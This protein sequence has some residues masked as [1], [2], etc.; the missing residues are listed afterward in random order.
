MAIIKKSC[1]VCKK[2]LVVLPDFLKYFLQ[3]KEM[4]K[5]ATLCCDGCGAPIPVEKIYKDYLENKNA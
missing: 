1:D 2:E 4:K 3:F 5:G